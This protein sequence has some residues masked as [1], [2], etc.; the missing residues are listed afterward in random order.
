M[1]NGRAKTAELEL[2]EQTLQ[3]ARLREYTGYDYFDGMSS[4]VLRALPVENKWLNILVQEGIKRAPVNVRPLFL[5]EQRQNFKGTALF[6]IA[7]TTAYELTGNELYEREAK[8][9]ADWL[10]DHQS[11]EYPGF[12]GGHR[13]R[14]QQLRELRPA[15]TP[16]VV[17]TSYA[18]KAL[19]S[20]SN[21]GADHV[22]TAE[23]TERFV[24]EALEYREVEEGALI[25]YHPLETGDHVTINGVAVGARLLVDLYD[26]VGTERYLDRA[27]KLLDY[28]VE[29][30]TE[31]G[32]WMYREPASASHLSM[33]NHHNGFIVESLLRYAEV[34]DS[35]RYD[36]ALDRALSFYKETLFD[37]DGAPNWDEKNRYPKDIHAAAQGIILF[38]MAGDT[39]FARRILEWT[40]ENLYGG[41]GQFYYQKRRFY[42]KRFTLM[43]WCQAWMS[44]ALACYLAAVSEEREVTL[45]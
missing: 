28:V 36:E 35:D 21:L 32:G 29:H 20:V 23:S 38:S 26:H 33:D 19:L 44:Y 27:T 42:T 8:S 25:D 24:E 4:G 9:L 12:C 14:M 39:E 13:H 34:A 18:V 41:H 40:L 30:Q 10:V 17:T 43:R 5:V 31:L 22:A 1:T 11:Q 37:P 45:A 15:N 7:N 6:A 3:Y 16:N 2:L